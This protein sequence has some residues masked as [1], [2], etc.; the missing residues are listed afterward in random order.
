MKR[1]ESR[2]AELGCADGEH[3]FHQIDVL[4]IE[5]DRLADPQPRDRDQAEQRRV[6]E[7]AHA[8]LGFEP[9]GGCEERRDLVR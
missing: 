3:S 6:G 1:H 7:A 2:L 4:S 9:A 5:L 8:I